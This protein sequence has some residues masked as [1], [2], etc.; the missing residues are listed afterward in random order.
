M[1]HFHFW[2][3]WQGYP[4]HAI[5][6]I[7]RDYRISATHQDRSESVIAEVA[8]NHQRNRHHPA[9]LD[10]VVRIRLEI[11]GTHGLPRAQIY[12][13]RVFEKRAGTG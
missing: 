11:L 8:S 10:G 4:V 9:R 5:P 12:G 3:S 7:I 2:Q 6:S 13:I 1:N